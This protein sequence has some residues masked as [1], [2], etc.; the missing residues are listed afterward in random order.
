MGMLRF[1]TIARD[2]LKD[3]WD[4]IAR[5]SITTA[6]RFLDRLE[7]KCRLLADNPEIGREHPELATSLRSFPA[8]NYNIFYRPSKNGVDVVRI[9][10][11]SRD[12]DAVF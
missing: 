2:D 8:G 10:S 9:L 11:A 6:S 5:D 12:I 3:I 1:T 7:D 4:F